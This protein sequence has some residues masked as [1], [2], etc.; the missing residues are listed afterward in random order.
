MNGPGVEYFSATRGGK[1]AYLAQ[2]VDD[3]PSS[4]KVRAL[5]RCARRWSN[6]DGRRGGACRKCKALGVE[7]G[8]LGFGLALDFGVQVAIYQIIF[9]VR[10]CA[11]DLVSHDLQLFAQRGEPLVIL[12]NEEVC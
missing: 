6:Q 8:Y 4:R 7:A 9:V 2:Q 11:R 12:L 5:E 3:C 10:A 1:E